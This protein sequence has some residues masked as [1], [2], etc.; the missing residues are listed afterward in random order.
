MVVNI[1][2]NQ[3][4]FG[5]G[6]P[7][8]GSVEVVVILLTAFVFAAVFMAFKLTIFQ[9]L[10][11]MDGSA[12]TLVDGVIPM[13]PAATFPLDSKNHMTDTRTET[14]FVRVQDQQGDMGAFSLCFW[15]GIDPNS[16]EGVYNAL[17]AKKPAAMLSGDGTAYHV[18][19]PVFMR[20]IPKYWYVANGLNPEL[21]YANN[22]VALVKCPII[23]LVVG[24]DASSLA[25][26]APYFEVEFNHMEGTT[27][28]AITNVPNSCFVQDQYSAKCTFFENSAQM[29]IH[30]QLKLGSP[31]DP[32]AMHF[33]TFVFQEQY[34]NSSISS[35]KRDLFTKVSAYIDGSASRQDT[36][37]QGQMRVSSTK[38]KV[39]PLEL[40]AFQTQSDTTVQAAV[41]Q[42]LNLSK[43]GNV[44]YYSYPLDGGAVSSKYDAGI[45]TTPAT[46]NKAP[47]TA[48]VV[49]GNNDR[50]LVTLY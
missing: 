23:W 4:N 43:I 10:T 46:A 14:D 13:T 39:L 9:N 26:L 15:I 3:P 40:L 17:A 47:A 2:R 22:A 31:T 27:P 18:K 28:D 21:N 8:A 33:M 35:M 45:N 29:D 36:Y 12:L 41:A 37:F 48:A 19:V 7:A 44:V 5:V 25:P 32:N 16:L 6:N 1:F 49:Q 30:N 20:G 11:T 42:L 38:V 50:S 24:V 34:V